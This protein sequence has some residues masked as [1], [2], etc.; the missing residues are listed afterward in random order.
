MRALK[1]VLLNCSSS[2]GYRARFETGGVSMKHAARAFG[3]RTAMCAVGVLLLFIGTSPGAA[4]AATLHSGLRF[5]SRPSSRAGARA[6]HRPRQLREHL[7]DRPQ[8]GAPFPTADGAGRPQTT[9]SAR[10][11]YIW[12]APTTLVPMT[13]STTRATLVSPS[14]RSGRTFRRTTVTPGSGSLSTTTTALFPAVARAG[15][16]RGRRSR[17]PRTATFTRC[18]QIRSARTESRQARSSICIARPS[19]ALSGPSRMSRRP[20]RG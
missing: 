4:A 3:R 13:T 18:S 8:A 7:R 12:C 2:A 1:C 15:T 9:P 16:S 10:S 11:T 5:A 19:M 20:T 6:G 17:W 14:I